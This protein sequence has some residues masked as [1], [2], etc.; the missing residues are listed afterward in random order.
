VH[1]LQHPLHQQRAG[2]PVGDALVPIYSI[3]PSS[4]SST[5]L[6]SPVATILSIVRISVVTTYPSIHLLHVCMQ[7]LVHPVH[8]AV[9]GPLQ[10]RAAP[11]AVQDRESHYTLLQASQIVGII[12]TIIIRQSSSSDIH[13]HHNHHLHHHHQII[14]ITI[15]VCLLYSFIHSLTRG[16]IQ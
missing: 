12:I 16:L 13:N 2:H 4:P 7:L 8:A 15:P 14:I 11:Q 10:T 6:L 5:H 1:Y 9:D 3:S